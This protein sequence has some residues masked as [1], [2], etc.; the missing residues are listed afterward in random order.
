[1][2]VLWPCLATQTTVALGTAPCDAAFPENA[3]AP[4]TVFQS[5]TKK[6]LSGLTLTNTSGRASGL[7]RS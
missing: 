2:A 5:T 6:R 4:P 3:L 7:A 1:M